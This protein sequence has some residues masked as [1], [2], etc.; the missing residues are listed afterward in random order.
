M[1]AFTSFQR[2]IWTSSLALYIA[3]KLKVKLKSR[4]LYKRYALGKYFF[5]S[6][7]AL[8]LLILTLST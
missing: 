6:L 4:E 5:S 1:S 7:K 3:K 8:F 2:H